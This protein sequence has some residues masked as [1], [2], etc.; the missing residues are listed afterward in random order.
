MWSF[1]SGLMPSPVFSITNSNVPLPSILSSVFLPPTFVR[2][3]RNRDRASLT[4]VPDGIVYD[5]EK[6]LA[7]LGEILRTGRPRRIILRI[8][9]FQTHFLNITAQFLQYIDDGRFQAGRRISNMPLPAFRVVMFRKSLTRRVNRSA[10][11]LMPLT[12]VEARSDNHTFRPIS[13]PIRR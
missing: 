8:R 12:A 11:V 5:D 3:G 9:R 13:N 7:H 4:V 2:A 6:D 10:E 1:S